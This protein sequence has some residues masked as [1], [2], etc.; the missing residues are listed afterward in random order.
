MVVNKKFEKLCVFAASYVNNRLYRF[1]DTSG[2]VGVSGYMFEAN[3]NYE[4]KYNEDFTFEVRELKH[5]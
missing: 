5:G 1:K 3:Q 2:K 4:F